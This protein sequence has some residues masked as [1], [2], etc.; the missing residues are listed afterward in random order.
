MSTR[1]GAA[2]SVLSD[3]LHRLRESR[4]LDRAA[5]VGLIG[6]G[7]FYLLLAALVTALVFSGSGKLQANANGAL[8][9]VSDTHLGELLLIAAAVGFASFGLLRIVG[10]ATDRRHG[11]LRR[12]STAGQGVLHLGLAAG[13][14][15][16]VLGMHGIG[17]EDE[18]RRTAETV[19]NLPGGRLILGCVGGI[20]LAVCTWQLLVT[21]SGGFADSLLLDT[22][23]HDVRRLTMVA[24]RIGIPAR[25]LAFAPLGA[26]LLVAAIRN[27]PAQ[28]KGLDGFLLQLTEASWGRAV[29]LLVA[30]GLGV[31]AVYSFLEARFRQVSAGA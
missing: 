1:T 21:I 7:I 19:L 31:F 24:A 17:S 10:A 5:R 28:A 6:R 9:A 12:L 2:A 22:A 29:V 15:G 14:T 4:P 11:R 25:A 8:S 30:V 27:Q 18:Q 26:F 13:T 20:M 3:G 23:E 16:F